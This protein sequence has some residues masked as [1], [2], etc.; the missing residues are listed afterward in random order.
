M[1]QTTYER[2]L[3]LNRSA[4]ERIRDDVRRLHGGQYVGIARGELIAASPRYDEVS[5]AIRRLD[6]PPEF[7]LIFDAQDEPDFEVVEDYYEAG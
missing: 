5:A 2:E 1:D 6:P 7:F 3:A 4:W